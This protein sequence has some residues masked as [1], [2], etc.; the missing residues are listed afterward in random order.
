MIIRKQAFPRGGLIGN[1]SDGYFG[2]TIALSFANFRAEVVLY[3]TPEL[4][5]LPSLRD[6][7]VFA[8]ISALHEDVRLFGYYGGIRLLK[9]TIKRFL[10]HCRAGGHPLHARNFTIR[11]TSDIP[12]LVGLAGSSA[13]ITACM[14]CLMEFYNVRIARPQLANL[15][16]SVETEEL[17][18]AAGLQD[19]VAQAYQGVVFMDFDRALMESRGY[20]RYEAID[21]ALLPPLYIA[22]R[23]DLSECSDVVHTRLRERYNNRDP[24]VLEAIEFWRELTV[25]V[26][27]LLL[28]GR[29][30]EIGPLLNMNF[31]RRAKVMP[32]SPGNMRMVQTARAVGASAKFTG[33]GGAIIGTYD[34]ESMFDAL[35]AALGALRVE[36]IKPVYAPPFPE[37]P[38]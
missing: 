4:A 37:E 26:R 3:E 12:H 11:Y 24:E 19:R 23:A 31:D 2:R 33:S 29:G 22:Y 13:I 14:R 16:L 18:I 34:D 32:I 9:A 28:A 35:R 27:D 20:G 21:P 30:R 1:P 8:D 15:V 7:S 17:G 5:I 25:R 38:A 10:D 36:V 6:H